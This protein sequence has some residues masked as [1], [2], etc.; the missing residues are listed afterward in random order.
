MGAMVRVSG[1]GQAF[2]HKLERLRMNGTDMRP[3]LRLIGQVFADAQRHQFETE[4]RHYGPGWVRLT[5]KYAARKAKLLPGLRILQGATGALEDAAAPGI[6][7]EFPIY[8]LGGRRIEVGLSDA[9]VPY[10]K[11]HQNGTSKMAARPVM[12]SPSREDRKKITKVLHTHLMK[13]VGV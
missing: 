9:D 11:Y 6:A 8:L 4:G 5:P 1:Q 10:A 2:V 3:A 12:G 7:E 13:G